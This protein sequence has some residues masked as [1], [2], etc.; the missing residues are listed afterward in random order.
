MRYK[1][2]RTGISQ[3]DL[4]QDRGL[5]RDLLAQRT[6]WCGLPAH[7]GP[8]SFGAHE[9]RSYSQPS[10][11]AAGLGR[12]KLKSFP[13]TLHY[14]CALSKTKREK[15]EISIMSTV[16]ANRVIFTGENSAIRLSNNDSDSFTT[17]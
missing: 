17:N 8:V 16:D 14:H 5:W 7:T 4:P 1:G 3:Q 11:I 10:T 2:T 9:G 15:R 6:S 13:T 12:S